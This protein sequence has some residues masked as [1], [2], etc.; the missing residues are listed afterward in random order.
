MAE[1][2]TSASRAG[3]GD[4]HNA[5]TSRNDSTN[6]TLVFNNHRGC[7]GAVLDG[8]VRYGV[9]LDTDAG[10]VECRDEP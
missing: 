3:D 7:H 10:E 5:E 6:N 1:E 9:L 4:S 2:T 8:I